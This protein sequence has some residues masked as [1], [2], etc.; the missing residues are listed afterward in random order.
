MFIRVKECG[1]AYLLFFFSSAT[2]ISGW[3]LVGIKCSETLHFSKERRGAYF[4]S[5]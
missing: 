3:P 5:I 4:F 2:L 1:F